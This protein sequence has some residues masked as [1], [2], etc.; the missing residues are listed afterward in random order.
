MTIQPNSSKA[1]DAHVHVWSDDLS[2]YSFA[3]GFKIDDCVV[4]AFLPEDI[5]NHA[6]PFG[7]ERIVLV[8]MSY[9]GFDN[10]YMTDVIRT[11]EGVFSGIAVI[12]QNAKKP[13]REMVRLARM[14]V[15]GFRIKPEGAPVD[16]WLDG[17]VWDRMFSAGTDL[18]LALCPLI[19]PEALPSL[20]RKCEEY[21]D[22][23]VIID[24]LC[25]IGADGRINPDHVDAL[26]RMAD[27][28]SVMMKV[29]AFYALGSK[30]SPYE[31]LIPL[32]QRVLTAFGAKRLMWA[33]DCPFQVM[34]GHN[35]GDSI[36]LVR[37]LDF[38]SDDERA[39][40]LR[41]TAENFFFERPGA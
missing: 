20:S 1:V 36:S 22:T 27:F 24:H 3:R 19:D 16:S 40:V 15:C 35:Y 17:P 30:T 34:D 4:P 10:R 9:Y 26:C 29:S 7:V 32:I 11:H 31:D 2:R 6:R 8:Q 38:L 23:P 33:S 5:L 21:P 41:R 18:H 25:R 12:D 39:D 37:N 28:P 14:G 13:D